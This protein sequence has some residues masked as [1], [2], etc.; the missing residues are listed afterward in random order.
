M[1]NLFPRLIALNVYTLDLLDLYGSDGARDI[2][3]Q[4]TPKNMA[5]LI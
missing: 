4:L 3:A 2:I 5:A 1:Q